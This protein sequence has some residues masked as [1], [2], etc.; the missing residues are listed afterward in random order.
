MWGLE[1]VKGMDIFTPTSASQPWVEGCGGWR[2]R[3]NLPH[4]PH[5]QPDLDQ[6]IL[7]SQLVTESFGMTWNSLESMKM[8][9]W[10]S[11][12]YR[13][14]FQR[15]CLISSR[16]VSMSSIHWLMLISIRINKPKKLMSHFSRAVGVWSSVGMVILEQIKSYVEEAGSSKPLIV[17]GGAGTGKSSLMARVADVAQTMALNKK[18]P[19]GGKEGW[20]VF[21][22]FVGAVPGSTDLE[23]CI[24]RL[25]KELDAF[26][27]ATAPKNL[28]ATCQLSCGVLSNPKTRPVIVI[29]DA[30]NQF[31]DDKSG[32]VLSWLPRKLSPQV[33]VMLSMIDDTPPHKILQERSNPPVDIKVTPLDMQAREQIVKEMLGKYNKKL[34]QHQ[35]VS[36][37]SKKSSE[38]PLWLSIACEELRVFGLFDK[39]TDKINSLDDGLLELLEQVF[40]RFEEENGGELLT[41]TLCLLETS[42]TGLLETELLKILG[43][44]D[45]LIPDNSAENEK[46]SKEKESR[47]KTS[48][49]IGPLPAYKWATVFRALKPFIRPFGDSGEG[50]LDFYHRALSKAVRKKYFGGAAG[51]AKYDQTWWHH[52][53]AD[54]FFEVNVIHRK[55]EELPAHLLAIN[56]VERLKV[57]LTNWAVF[58]MLY[59]EDY[60]TLLLK[61]WREGLGKDWQ[62]V[63]KAEYTACLERLDEEEGEGF[64]QS[65]KHID[66]LELLNKTITLEENELGARPE[67]MVEIFALVV[68]SMMR[69]LAEEGKEKLKLYE[70]VDVSQ[71]RELRPAIEYAR[72]SIALRETLDGEIHKYKLGRIFIQ[73]AFNLQSWVE[74]GGDNSLSVEEAESEAKNNVEKAIT[75]FTELKSDGHLADALMTKGV[76]QPRGS[77]EQVEYYKSSLELCLQA[78]G[79]NS[80]LTTRI[81]LNT[82]ICYEDRR[83]YEEAY[84]WFVKWQDV[85]EEVFGYHHP[86]TQRCRNCLSEAT[87]VAIKR[88]RDMVARNNDLNSNMEVERRE[89]IE[90][91]MSG[92]SDED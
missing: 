21:Y 29:M 42:S 63:L 74:V 82:G 58:D 11:M 37:L 32:S 30:L 4:P 41:S 7:C 66:A 40:T 20:H 62:D 61:H 26:N 81:Y 64:A 59:N 72:K 35:M 73:L 44:E 91:Y 13:K 67:R 90:D 48:K 39:V 49:D 9:K 55:V 50:R 6:L 24:K 76:I 56:D 43:D 45:N 8:E 75:I 57:F 71:K 65:G 87:Y 78:Y 34:D 70:Y 17:T 47:E 88:K 68:P 12:G 89:A 36:L 92:D 18:I 22:H 85:C 3:P 16:V 60:S 28:E 80:V 77:D 38:N 27:D 51:A 84:D 52:K 14:T 19:G 2:S 31:D 23:R 1:E 69:V 86:R 54:Y 33:R 46:E 15:R 53:L 10:S 5:H 25:L 79:E 83:E